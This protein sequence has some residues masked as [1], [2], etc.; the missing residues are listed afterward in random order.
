MIAP[1]MVA[2]PGELVRLTARLWPVSLMM[3]KAL[4]AGLKST[5][6]RV[7]DSA[8]NGSE[9]S[10]ESAISVAFCVAAPVAGLTV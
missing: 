6:K 4:A 7:P 2:L 5:L 3:R 1:F 8:V 10:A 9:V